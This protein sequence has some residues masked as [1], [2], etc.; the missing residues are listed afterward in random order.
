MATL[1]GCFTAAKTPDWTN[2]PTRGLLI[3]LISHS[4]GVRWK[5][6]LNIFREY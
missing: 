2:V 3:F 6:Y 5:A 4:E 1:N